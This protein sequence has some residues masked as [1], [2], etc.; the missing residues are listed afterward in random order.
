VEAMSWVSLRTQAQFDLPCS[1]CGSFIDVE[2][3]HIRHIRKSAYELIPENESYKKIMALRNRKQIP[4]CRSCHMT[5]IHKGSYDGV[6]LS[7]LSPVYKMVDNRIIHIES[8]IK[9]GEQY[10]AKSLEEKGWTP[11]ID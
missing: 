10:F 2:Q 9:P 3:H 8:F 4:V 6:A 5:L 1:V 11:A 7:K